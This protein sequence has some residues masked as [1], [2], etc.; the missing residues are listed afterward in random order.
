MVKIWVVNELLT[1]RSQIEMGTVL[2][3]V[4]RAKIKQL[5]DFYDSF[6]MDDIS[7][8]DVESQGSDLSHIVSHKQLKLTIHEETIN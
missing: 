2:E 4:G 6:N 5:E 1:L 7:L 3:V 8:E